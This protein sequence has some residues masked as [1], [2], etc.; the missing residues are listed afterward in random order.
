MNDYVLGVEVGLDSNARKNRVGT[1]M[2]NLVENTLINF[3]Y[4]LGVNLFKQVST[5]ELKKN[6]GI[7]IDPDNSKAIKKFDFVV[8]ENNIVYAIECNFYS[9]SGSKLNEVSRSYKQLFEETKNISNFKFLWITDGKGWKST[10]NNLK[11][12][13][14][15]M[16]TVFNIN[17]LKNGVFKAYLKNKN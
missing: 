6:F 5:K 8:L 13:Y 4:K 1:L 9:S 7:I 3:G 14:E 2:E 15:A 11:E 17:E 16:E 12:T 10:K